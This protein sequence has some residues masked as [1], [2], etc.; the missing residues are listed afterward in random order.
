MLIVISD[1]A[2]S[3]YKPKLISSRRVFDYR[4]KNLGECKKESVK[5]RCF[6]RKRCVKKHGSYKLRC[7]KFHVTRL[8][9]YK[10]TTTCK[11]CTKWFWRRCYRV[12]Q[13]YK[14]VTKCHSS[15]RYE[16]C[17]RRTTKR[18]NKP[19]VVKRFYLNKN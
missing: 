19:V 4:N 13:K 14:Y 10:H 11:F 15:R 8:C 3:K 6:S 7:I 1:P 17:A 2:H 16:S 12:R 5:L 18:Y 9:V